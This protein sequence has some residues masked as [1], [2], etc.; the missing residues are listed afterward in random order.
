MRYG[1]QGV[2]DSGVLFLE[3][4]TKARGGLSIFSMA[5]IR[6]ESANSHFRTYCTDCVL[7]LNSVR[8]ERRQLCQTIR[9]SWRCPG[10]QLALPVSSHPPC[11]IAV[12]HYLPAASLDALSASCKGQHRTCSALVP[13]LKL[14][15][16]PHQTE[17]RHGMVWY[18]SQKKRQRGS[19]C[20][21]SRSGVKAGVPDHTY[22]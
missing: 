13:G 10:P 4:G 19:P 6:H 20:S 3:T 11:L 16:F 12:A 15:L 5:L 8:K 14:S 17:V 21:L 9:P 1:L 2:L 18:D 7:T 22:K